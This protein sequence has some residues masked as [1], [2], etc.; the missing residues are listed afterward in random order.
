MAGVVCR[1]V[2]SRIRARRAPE[3]RLTPEYANL[4]PML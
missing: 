2:Q 4:L 3:V 1:R